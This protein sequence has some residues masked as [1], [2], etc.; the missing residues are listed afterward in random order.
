MPDTSR[1]FSTTQIAAWLG[2]SRVTVFRWIKEGAL[3]AYKV[4]RIYVICIEDI[5]KMCEWPLRPTIT[6]MTEE[7]ILH[8]H[9][10]RNLLSNKPGDSFTYEDIKPLLELAEI[11]KEAKT[12]TKKEFNE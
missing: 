11:M 2:V 9:P 8:Y 4:G 12:E 10:L 7:E 3:K 6:P 5:H 1:Y